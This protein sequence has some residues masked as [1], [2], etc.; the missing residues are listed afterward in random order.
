VGT[1]LGW[2]LFSE[3][4]TL[5]ALKLIHRFLELPLFG[6]FVSK[7]KLNSLFLRQVRAPQTRAQFRH[8]L[9]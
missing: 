1:H 9:Y 6:G 5:P 2:Y 4:A 7:N 8:N 3:A